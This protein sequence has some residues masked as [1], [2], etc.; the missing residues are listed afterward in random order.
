[1][2]TDCDIGGT[3]RMLFKFITH[4]RSPRFRHSVVVLKPDGQFKENFYNAGI[5]LYFAGIA[6]PFYAGGLARLCARVRRLSPDI[7]HAYL[8]HADFCARLIAPLYGIRAVISSVRNENIGSP[9]RE[10]MLGMTDC[11]TRKVTVVSRQVARTIAAKGITPASKI[12]V[13]PN[14]VD[15]KVFPVTERAKARE[16][17]GI[18]P[19]E[20]VIATVA[21]L[22]RKKGHRVL[23]DACAL[24]KGRGCSFTALWAGDGRCRGEL[25]NAICRA[26][27]SDH[28]R[29][30]GFLGDAGVVFDA[31]DVFVLPSFWEGMPNA[32]LEAGLHRVPIVASRVGGIPEIIEQRIHGILVRPGDPHELFRA[33]DTVRND[34]ALASSLAEAAFRRVR[35]E[36]TI[37][38]TVEKTLSLYEEV[39]RGTS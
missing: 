15:A 4:A 30:L 24:L 14:G 36:F 28:I 20:F 17:L 26:G 2:I 21:T 7:V 9:L 25:E 33:I 1:M 10:R 31:A 16:A 5:P 39:L 27:L 38:K 32:V 12:E 8:F 11:L 35:G 23:I 34:S 37:Q 6:P 19:D 29:L 22:E 3:E 13:I 18:S